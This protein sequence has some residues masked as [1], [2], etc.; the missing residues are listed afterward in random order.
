MDRHPRRV[1]TVKNSGEICFVKVS[2]V[3]SCVQL[4]NQTECRFMIRKQ[5]LTDGI[6]PTV[7]AR[8]S[9]VSPKAFL[10]S[11]SRFS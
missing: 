7:E 5:T 8:N 3:V 6:F 1:K 11:N 10:E 9:G 4:W 2:S